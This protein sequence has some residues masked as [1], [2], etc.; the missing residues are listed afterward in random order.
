MTKVWGLV[1][2]TF[3]VLRYKTIAEAETE[4]YVNQQGLSRKFIFESVKKS[5]ERLQ[6]DYIDVLQCE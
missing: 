6:L 5:L 3:K 1:P 4:G 2:R